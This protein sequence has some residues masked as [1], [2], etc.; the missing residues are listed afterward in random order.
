MAVTAKKVLKPITYV[1]TD[2]ENAH[3][4]RDAFIAKRRK[5]RELD[6]RV[7]AFE[8]Q[9]REDMN[10][11]EPAVET[12]EPEEPKEPKKRKKKS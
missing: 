4:S 1:K 10:K 7:N 12:E 6:A 9:A 5:Q 8:K 2:P 3:I 11:E